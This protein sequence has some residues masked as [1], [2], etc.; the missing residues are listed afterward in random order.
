MK[1]IKDIQIVT[2]MKIVTETKTHEEAV[3][4]GDNEDLKSFF[5]RTRSKY[6][7]MIK[8]VLS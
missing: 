5:A 6:L 2:T 3:T 8:K 1:D 4:I 7:S